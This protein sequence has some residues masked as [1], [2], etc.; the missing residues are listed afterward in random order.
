VSEVKKKVALSASRIKTAQSCS[1]LYHAKYNL[2]CCDSGNSGSSRGS[3][4]HEIFEFLGD[5]K[6][7][8][9]YQTII[10]SQDAFKSKKVLKIVK[11]M[12]KELEVDDPENMQSMNEMIVNGL[13]HDFFGE[14]LGKPVISHS[15]KDF[16]FEVNENGF[17]Y[18]VKG[19]IDK[20]FIYE[21][22]TALI[23]D[24]KSSKQVFAGKDLDDNLQD[25]MYTLAVKRE[26][27]EV[28]KIKTEFL[29]LKFDPRVDGLVE[30]PELS[31]DE[32]EGFEDQLSDVQYYLDNF[33]EETAL[34]NMA[35]R[36]DYPKD[37]SF[38]G[39]IM[40]GRAKHPDAVKKNGEKMWK[41]AYKFKRDF[42]KIFEP[43]GTY[44]TS[45]VLEDEEKFREKY[46]GKTFE[47]TTYQ[48]C[49]SFA[50]LNRNL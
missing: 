37:G 6:N 5:V 19:F 48:G 30:M 22:G 2:K 44:I 50:N 40:C 46:K 42:W 27:P 7:I 1:W 49:P 32:L 26:F 14:A 28:K 3:I 35:A 38:G 4:C 33:T 41:C 47:R 9:E 24:F 43:D 36:Q 45:C 17:N 20:L 11:K 10:D 34:E 16:D 23:R 29:F 12:A 18:K 13:N 25:L 8:K 15:E 21:D 39:P 31:V